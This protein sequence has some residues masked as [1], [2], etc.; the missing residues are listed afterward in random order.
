MIKIESQEFFKTF[1]HPQDLVKFS[2]ISVVLQGRA[3]K[4]NRKITSFKA[5]FS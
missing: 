1:I 2:S 4:L 5:I 3:F